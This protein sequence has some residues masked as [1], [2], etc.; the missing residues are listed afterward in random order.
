MTN[1]ELLA[2]AKDLLTGIVAIDAGADAVYIGASHH[3]ARAAAGNS[4]DDIAKLCEYAHR[5][6]V[7]VYVTLNTLVYDEEIDSVRALVYDLYRAGVDALIVQDMALLEMDIPPIELHASTQCDTR[8]PEKARFLQD[9][10]FSQIVLPREMSLEEIRQVRQQTTVPL[11]G[12]VHGALCVCYSGDCRASLVNGGRS[13][14]RGECAQVCRLPFDLVDGN[15]KTVVADR[16]LL[17]LKDMNRL[18]Q[19]GELAEAGISSFKI[20]GRLKSPA[21]VR[22]VTAAYSEALNRLVEANPDRYKRASAGVVITDFRP[23]VSKSFN[24]GFTPYFLKDIQPAKGQLASM[25][26]PKHVGEAV[27]RVVSAGKRSIV[28][29][30]ASVL[31]NG[32]GLGFFDKQGKF[33]GFR[34]NRVEGKTVYLLNDIEAIP[35]K[36]TVIYRNFDKAFADRLESSRSRR[37]VPIQASLNAT[38][39]GV[40]LT[41]RDVERNCGVTVMLDGPFDTARTP[42]LDARRRVFEKTG[43]TIYVVTK[44]E[45]NVGSSVFIPASALTDLRR[46]AIAAL[47]NNAK[48]TYPLTLRRKGVGDAVVFYRKKLDMHDN[49]ANRL[50][51]AFYAKHGATVAEP[52]LE[53]ASDD[54]RSDEI[55]IM[56]S[57]YCLRR[58][59]GAC[60]K[61]PAGKTF[62]E[63]LTLVPIDGTTRPMRLDFDC[64]NCRMNVIAL[65]C[66]KKIAKKNG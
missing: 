49:V 27:G 6:R 28:L 51:A 39:R 26:T 38:Q 45:D 53:V 65:P 24:R 36:G 4:V 57:R 63:P 1:L 64:A 2:P 54:K 19:L 30:E 8:T 42:Q 12:F 31:N 29:S 61:T 37:V 62:K 50:S 25:L 11:E 21:Y 5:L 32:D 35:S 59:L 16:H 3:G 33:I 13:A 7:R 18:S 58:E 9:V 66:E 14:N 47:D 60:L 56:T 48:A 22:N 15:G 55:R 41:L 17:S 46:R 10:G 52:A 23:D 44:V 20:E 43:D 34:A 40:S